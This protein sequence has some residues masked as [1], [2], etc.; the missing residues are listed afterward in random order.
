MS[1]FTRR[2]PRFP[3]N[4]AE[5]KGR[6]I[7]TQLRLSPPRVST[8]ENVFGFGAG[9]SDVKDRNERDGDART[10][11]APNQRIAHS[12]PWFV[13]TPEK[14]PDQEGCRSPREIH[15]EAKTADPDGPLRRREAA[16]VPEASTE[17]TSIE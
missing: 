12:M 17:P 5:S 9:I 6:W 4:F 11:Q 2:D 3:H 14:E 16:S 15:E 8:A 13:G 1:P 10:S 7:T